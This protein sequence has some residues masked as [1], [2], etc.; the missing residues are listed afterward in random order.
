VA[1]VQRGEMSGVGPRVERGDT[2]GDP[3]AGGSLHD[4]HCGDGWNRWRRRL[5]DKRKTMTHYGPVLDRRGRV[6]QRRDGA[7]RLGGTND[8]RPVR[9]G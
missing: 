4:R 6:G 1:L 8:A 7:H 9:L 3:V 2:G 5:V